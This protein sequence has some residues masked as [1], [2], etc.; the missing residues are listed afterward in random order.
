MF[1]KPEWFREKTFGWGLTPIRWQG[2]LYACVWIGVLIIPF[3]VLLA[4]QQTWQAV[5][6]L[7]FSLGGL[8]WDVRDILRSMRQKDKPAEP[9]LYIDDDN[10][11]VETRNFDLHLRR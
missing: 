9:T 6:W 8:M 10:P 7:L 11:N 4:R 1:G 5:V 2:W 3:L